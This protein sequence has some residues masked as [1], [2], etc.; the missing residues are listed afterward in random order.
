MISGIKAVDSTSVD[1]QEGLLK[2]EVLLVDDDEDF[3][4]EASDLLTHYGFNVVLALSADQAE[5]KFF[6]NE[7]INIVVTDIAMPGRNGLELLSGLKNRFGETRVYDSIVITGHSG[8]NEAIQALQLGAVDFI[9]KP[10]SP[11]TLLDSIK[12][13]QQRIASSYSHTEGVKRLRRQLNHKSREFEDALKDLEKIKGEA[14]K[15]LLVDSEFLY[16]ISHEFR[17]PLNVITGIGSLL[18]SGAVSPSGEE[19][20][21][22]MEMLSNAAFNIESLLEG[23]LTYVS[24]SSKSNHLHLAPFKFDEFVTEIKTNY[25]V[26]IKHKS[27]QFNIECA[28]R[29]GVLE[30]DQAMLT[31]AVG[32]LLDN[33]IKFSPIGSQIDLVVLHNEKALEIDVI[34]KGPGMSAE[35]IATACKPFRKIDGGPTQSASG[36]GLG[37]SLATLIVELHGG[38]LDILSSVGV[39]TTVRIRISG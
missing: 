39:G 24:L 14:D 22:Y 37:I 27:Q 32:L 18:K 4:E 21:L 13:A 7:D 17:T 11:K 34:D 23:V 26:P 3:L 8:C 10:V 15:S 2:T 35:E 38:S 29:T 6:L 36:I 20:K 9:M 28:D 31:R 5:E 1:L 16:S 19:I 33:A 25:E 30:A 12:K